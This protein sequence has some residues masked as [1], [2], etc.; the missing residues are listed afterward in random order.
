MHIALD[1]FLEQIHLLLPIVLHSF[2]CG[3]FDHLKKIFRDPGAFEFFEQ[4]F[5][6]HFPNLEQLGSER[7]KTRT[8]LLIKNN[9]CYGNRIITL[10]MLAE[11]QNLF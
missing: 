5:K 8:K 3:F 11:N 9:I 6:R 10:I 4:D 7:V 1:I 2:F